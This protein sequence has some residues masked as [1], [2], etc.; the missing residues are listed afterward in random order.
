[1]AVVCR[2]CVCVCVCVEAD[3]LLVLVPSD[4]SAYPVAA[5]FRRV[6]SASLTDRVTGVGGV[7]ATETCG[8]E[9]G[10]TLA[11]LAVSLG[12]EKRLSFW[13]IKS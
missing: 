1:M 9:A 5:S 6:L 10:Q 11:A 8:T 3:G 7:T 13:L 2:L 12:V 4:C